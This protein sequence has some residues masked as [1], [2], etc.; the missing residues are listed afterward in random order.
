MKKHP[1]GPMMLISL[2]VLSLCLG[3]AITGT[4]A[5]LSVTENTVYYSDGDYYDLFFTITNN[6]YNDIREFAIGNNK[7][8]DISVNNDASYA[9][10]HL[11]KGAIAEKDGD[12]NWRIVIEEIY[13]EPNEEFEY[14]YRY[15]TW[16]DNATDF[17]DFEKAF[18]YTSYGLWDAGFSDYLEV[19]FTNGYEGSTGTPMSP[20]AAYSELS[21]TITGE[22]SAVPIPGAALLFG[23]SLIGIVGTRMKLKK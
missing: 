6:G 22:T 16:L 9:S 3:S 5:S 13:Y 12:G 20:F 19:G 23:S 11:T 8:G 15:L 10:D 17:D 7:A 1:F 18:L 2:M 14:T 4:A 21:G